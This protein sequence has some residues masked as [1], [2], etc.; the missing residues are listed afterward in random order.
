MMFFALMFG[1]VALACFVAAI[2]QITK[3]RWGLVALFA[4]L[5]F[6]IGGA[7]GTMAAAA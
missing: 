7:A 3:A 4:V 2:I 5:A 6:A 1:V